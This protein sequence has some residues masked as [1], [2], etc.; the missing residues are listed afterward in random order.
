MDFERAQAGYSRAFDIYLKLFG[1]NHS[2]VSECCS[3]LCAVYKMQDNYEQAVAYG[4][5]A[6]RITQTLHASDGT[7]PDIA[8]NYSILGSTESQFGHH[9][10]AIDYYSKAL[11]IYQEQSCPDQRSTARTEFRLGLAY[12]RCKRYKEALPHIQAASDYYEAHPD[13]DPR[14]RKNTQSLL[15]K[16]LRGL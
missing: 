2:W 1:E 12:Y 11:A 3:G 4:A 8:S 14:N 5:R 16:L 15:A 10:A 13:A 6:L 9:E 7:H